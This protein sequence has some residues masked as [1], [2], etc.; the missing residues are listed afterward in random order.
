MI[1]N[2]YRKVSATAFGAAGAA[3][4]V[5]LSFFLED[6]GSRNTGIFLILLGVALAC[7]LV[8]SR[9]RVRRLFS[10]HTDAMLLS[11]VGIL[12][13]NAFFSAA[14]H[15][16]FFAFLCYVAPAPIVYYLFKSEFADSPIAR[17]VLVTV[18]LCA[19]C[20]ALLAIFEWISKRDIAYEFLLK[21]M[22]YEMYRAQGRSMATQIHPVNLA[23]YLCACL[24]VSWYYAATAGRRIARAW[25]VISALLIVA[26]IVTTLSRFSL[27][28]VAVSSIVFFRGR[29]KKT[30]AALAM[31]L[32]ALVCVFSYVRPLRAFHRLSIS[33][34]VFNRSPYQY[35]LSRM[36]LAFR[37][38]KD[39]PVRGVGLGNF[40]AAFDRY[41][42]KSEAFHTK[43]PEN[44]F[45]LLAVE[46][47]LPGLASF[48]AFLFFLFKD[49]AGYLRSRGGSGDLARCFCAGLASILTMM[50]TYDALFWTGPAFFFWMYCGALSS[51]I[52]G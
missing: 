24:P 16:A 34:I 40:K 11:Y 2:T 9:A 5:W 3:L 23:A 47:G 7:S 4:V 32:V 6:V 25:G 20:V 50:C 13:C 8:S 27:V 38:I 49:A 33:M 29:Q 14:R 42:D 26:G 19:T 28:A 31:A 44:S 10:W 52:Y 41:G 35:R 22:Y 39:H 45:L 12:A 37:M 46:S 15:G 48:L 21:N 51:M 30:A 43:T 36:G 17:W 1:P 18:N